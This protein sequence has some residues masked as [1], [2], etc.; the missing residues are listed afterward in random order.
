MQTLIDSHYLSLPSQGNVFLS[1]KFQQ[2]DGGTRILV[3]SIKRKIYLIEYQYMETYMEPVTKE[4]SFSCIQGKFKIMINV[5]VW[6]AVLKLINHYLRCFFAAGS[7]IASID[8]LNRSKT[9]D[10][11]V[12]GIVVLKV[13][14][15]SVEYLWEGRINTF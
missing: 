14:R 1:V 7:E 9:I 13:E 8:V 11:F 6:F 4:I 15:D 2:I 10:D 12:V 3:A 5:D